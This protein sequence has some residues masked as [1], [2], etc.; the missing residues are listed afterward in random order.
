MNTAVIDLGT[1]SLKAVVYSVQAKKKLQELGRFRQMV[2][3]GDNLFSDLELDNH[4]SERT[5]AAFQELAELLDKHK[6][7][8]YRA[9]A[10][11]ALRQ[12]TD[13]QELADRI[14]KESGIFLEIISGQEEARLIAMA[15]LAFHSPKKP[16]MLV[17]IGG[18]ST[19]L[20]FVQQGS[21][22]ES[23]SLKLGAARCQQQFLLTVPPAK[24]GEQTLR[25][26]V[27]K[28]CE[29]LITRDKLQMT[30][31]IGSSGSIRAIQRLCNRTPQE[32][33]VFELSQLKILLDRIRPLSVEKIEKLKLLES[34]RADIFLSACII[35]D[36]ICEIFKIQSIQASKASLKDG[37]LIE[38]LDEL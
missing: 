31:A 23:D 20:S 24:S 6:V 8:H 17:D 37:L 33:G 32:T 15:V 10:T 1:N 30:L 28:Q 5:L 16:C 35:L 21:V 3:L 11:S 25:Q 12:A 13:G 22:Y 34:S 18:G 2:R 9:I 4:A 36:E 7:K 29:P 14:Y 38:L 19:E 27:R 26:E